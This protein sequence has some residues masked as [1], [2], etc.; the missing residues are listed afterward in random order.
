MRA[1]CYLLAVARDLW[2]RSRA[3]LVC[4]IA[5]FRHDY[6][7]AGCAPTHRL[8][9]IFF[10]ANLTPLHFFDFV[11]IHQMEEPDVRLGR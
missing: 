7:V 6:R 10:L 2:S 1:T 3:S 5:Y 4:T 11:I 9:C 8:C